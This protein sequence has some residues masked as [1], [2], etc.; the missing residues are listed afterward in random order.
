MPT[1]KPNRAPSALVQAGTLRLS[2]IDFLRMSDGGGLLDF[3]CLAL[4]SR[5]F[6]GHM[7]SGTIA[8]ACLLLTAKYATSEQIIGRTLARGHAN[9]SSLSARVFRVVRGK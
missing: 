6:L 8:A 9:M 3:S 1:R 7:K 5:V 4:Q 2:G